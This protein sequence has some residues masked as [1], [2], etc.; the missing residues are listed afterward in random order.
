MLRLMM[1]NFKIKVWGDGACFSRPEM[2]VE[3]VSYD[4]ITPSAA[5]AIVEAILWKPAIQW[6]IERI[7]LLKPI[8]W[9]SVRRNEVGGKTT[10]PSREVMQSGKGA[11]PTIL[12]E[13][14]RQQR[15]GLLLR[16]VAYIIHA[17][18]DMTD[19]AGSEDNPVKFSQMFQRRLERGQCITQPYL[20][21]REFSALFA[22]AEPSDI[23]DP[24][25]L[26]EDYNRPLGWMLHDLDYANDRQP[27]FFK[28]NLENGS[29]D[30]RMVYAEV[31]R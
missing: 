19:R 29:V 12:I 2:K 6:H 31:S 13:S 23:P 20:G 4:V 14:D 25:I 22:P 28:A 7:D 9:Q 1:Q 24:T 3:R 11:V 5:R 30:T 10:L 15:A 21:C 26:Q 18:F 16:D 27:V 17:R 8:R